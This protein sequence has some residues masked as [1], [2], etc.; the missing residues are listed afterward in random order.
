MLFI[1]VYK[2]L[3]IIFKK[4]YCELI[5]VWVY[6]ISY[7][8]YFCVVISDGN[9][10]LVWEKWV[11]ILNYVLD[12]YEGYGELYFMCFYGFVNFRFWI[13]RGVFVILY[14]MF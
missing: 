2:N 9:G 10:D 3:D 7:Y 13:R 5:W 4:I 6:F 8:I 14:E 1:G 11:F 12:I